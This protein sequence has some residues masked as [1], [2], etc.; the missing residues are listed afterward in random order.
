MVM[1]MLT[2][3][4]I[5]HEKAHGGLGKKGE[6]EAKYHGYS[7]SGVFHF[8]TS[9]P[10]EAHDHL[11]R[12]ACRSTMANKNIWVAAGDGELGRVQVFVG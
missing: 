2:V 5:L 3:W 7:E 1:I 8:S 4:I 11:Y 12:S 10:K 6:T 9:V